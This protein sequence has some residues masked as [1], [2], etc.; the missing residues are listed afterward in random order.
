M[1]HTALLATAASIA[2]LAGA[3]SALAQPGSGAAAPPG[4]ATSSISTG[5]GG[6]T[7]PNPGAAPDTN[8]PG[9]TVPS[10]NAA[11]PSGGLQEVVVTA[12]KRT[13][14]AQKTAASLDV[15][16]SDT[17][18][19]QN[20]LQIQDLNA[21]LP[22]VQLLPFVNSIQVAI[23]GVQSN[24]IDPR[25]D[26]AVA[27]SVNGL[28]FD[29]PLPT[30]FAF[31]DVSR[32]EDLNGP[33]GTL[34]G[35]NAVGG[36]INIVTNQPTNKFGGSVTAEGGNLGANNFTGVLNVPVNDTLAVRVAY[37]RD[38]RDGYLGGYYDDINSDAARASVRWKPNEKLTVY[39]ESD[40]LHQ[41][42]HGSAQEA[43]PCNGAKPYSLIVPG[44]SFY[45]GGVTQPTGCT[46]FGGG[47][48][49]LGGTVD[50]FVDA[51]QLHVDYD[52]GWM[53]AT[54]ITGFV[55]THQRFLNN[56][57]ADNNLNTTRSN[58]YDY[59]EEIRFAGHDQATHAGGF[60]WQVG[61]FF[62]DSTG[63]F[64]QTTQL[65]YDNT[66]F[67]TL[68][69]APPPTG[70]AIRALITPSTVRYTGLP[71]SS[72]AGFLQAT[73]GIT[74][75]L[76]VTGGVRYT[77]DHKGVQQPGLMKLEEDENHTTYKGGLEYDLAPGKLLYANI[78]SGFVAGGPDGG[79]PALPQP[80]VKAPVYFRPE[81][82]TAYEVG[83]KNRFFGN[84]LQL[85]ADFYYYNFH[86]LQI[87]EPG[88][89]NSAAAGSTLV[90][91][92]AGALTTYGLEFN[93]QFALT[94][95][96]HF[97][98]SV[99]VAH[100]TYGGATFPETPSGA[101]TTTSIPSGQKLV[102]LP[103]VTALLGYDHTWNFGAGQ[104]LTASINT[105]ISSSYTL[106]FGTPI[107]AAFDTQP[108]YTMTDA[109]LSYS[110]DDSKYLIR[111][112]V[113][114]LENT[115]VNVYG[116]TGGNHIYGILAPRTY[117]VSV[118]ANF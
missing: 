70:P 53:T 33:Q 114:N 21:V 41:G 48:I 98:A 8:V 115:P 81:T 106:E 89:Y 95:V 94:P 79:N 61:G 4:G 87:T 55:G 9:P 7:P 58:N 43:Y 86:N 108:S 74:D 10:S 73:Y 45:I 22:S 102:N 104:A 13:S 56:P 42:G 26:P 50:S 49:R 57:N 103:L 99:T 24:F 84:R 93:G 110:F 27:V 118:T 2:I 111:G 62:F 88:T 19:K 59:S 101:P 38:R 37:Q 39:A 44:T 36:A 52:F 76:R 32:I 91:E 75:Q 29:R 18:A 112:Y 40:F 64:S 15:I 63:N 105:K 30:G 69:N 78:S 11:P 54:S 96:D 28:F 113:K 68:V 82:I 65:A 51:D 72:E 83:S 14:T 77:H 35:R 107:I 23:R 60:A 116:E 5:T 20:V 85:N 117:G 12:E 46:N 17:L 97:S 66:F 16:S 71:Q 1:R 109:S 34:Y 100:G 31:L 47:P 90:V 3:S 80:A 92:N 6:R 67:P 25:A